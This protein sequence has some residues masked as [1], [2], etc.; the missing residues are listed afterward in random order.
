MFECWHRP[1]PLK[2]GVRIC[3]HCGVAIEPCPCVDQFTFRKLDDR[4]TICNGSGWVAI[5]RGRNEKFQEALAVY[6]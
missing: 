1:G 4:C 5:V 3:R 6:A 2:H